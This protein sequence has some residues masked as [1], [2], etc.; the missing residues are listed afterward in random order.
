[1]TFLQPEDCLVLIVDDISQNIQL[2]MEILDAQGYSTTFARNGKQALERIEMAKPDLILLDLMMP[3]MNGLDVC[4]I[5][6]ANPD[7]GNIPIIFLTASEE[8]EN[9][10]EAFEKGAVDY[11]TKPFKT[12]ELL[13]R[14]KTHLTLKRTQDALKKA[15]EE[16]EKLATTDPLTEIANRRAI[17]EIGRQ[18]FLRSKRYKT[19]FCLFILDVDYFKKINDNYGH[20]IGDLV[21]ISMVSIV[22]NS[23]RKVDKLGR[24]GKLGRL[25][26]EE[27]II[28]LP[29]TSL[30][31]GIKVADRIRLTIEKGS[32]TTPI[33]TIKLTV[34]IGLSSYTADDHSISDIMK[35]ADNALYEAKE[36]GRNQVKAL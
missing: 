3:G 14:V 4:A 18:E 23:L 6:K 19:E 1:M 31:S 8:G 24:A 15:Y 22:N 7:Y 36:K 35:R 13:A 10:I 16:M 2:V 30:E 11:I 27:F 32:I 5:L 12:P 21:L 20:D 28:I 33:V 29:E 25:G 9:L 17:L 26:G 34:S